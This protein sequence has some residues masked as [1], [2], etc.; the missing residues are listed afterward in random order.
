LIDYFSIPVKKTNTEN[1]RKIMTEQVWYINYENGQVSELKG[2]FPKGSQELFTDEAFD[3]AI[4]FGDYYGLGF[5]LVQALP[6]QLNVP[7]VMVIHTTND[8]ATFVQG[9]YTLEEFCKARYC[10]TEK[11]VNYA[12]EEFLTARTGKI[13]FGLGY[14]V[15]KGPIKTIL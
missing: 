1:K 5:S 3:H 4:A 9:P 12:T 13:V 15:A 10:L 11:D 14:Y 2:P 7:T 8:C 6:E